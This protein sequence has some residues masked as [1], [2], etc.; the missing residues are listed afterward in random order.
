MPN[1]NSFGKGI[2]AVG[3][4]LCTLAML[5]LGQPAPSS[6]DDLEW[7]KEHSM[8]LQAPGLAKRFSGQGA[9]W[10]H[11]YALARPEDFVNTASVWFTAYPAAIIGRSGDSV[12]QT[13]G[14]PN[15]LRT[16]AKI[17]FDGIHTGPLKRAGSVAGTQY[18]PTIDGHFDRIELAIDP[19]FGT[20]A[21]YQAMIRNAAAR[22]ISIIGDLIPGHTGKGPDFRLAER[23]VAGFPGLYLMVEI[24]PEDWSLL[25]LV[26]KGEDSVNLSLEAVQALKDR[27]YIVGPLD[28]VIFARPGIKESNWS[29]TDVVTGAD[30]KDRRW[31]YLHFFKRGQPALNW[32]DPSFAAHRLEAADIIHS[33][34]VLGTRALRLD[35]NMFLGIGPRKGNRKAWLDGHPL[36]NGVT[37]T[38][39]M[40]IRKLGG[41]SFQELNVPLEKVHE[42][43][44]F[45]PELSY[46][47]T[48]RPAY[49]YA[50]V[51]GNAGPLRMILREMLA[52]EVRPM[53]M[54]HALQNHDE[55]MMELTH[56]RVHGEKTFAF[57]GEAQ[58][59]RAL[60]ARLHREPARLAT[61]DPAPYNER[62]ATSPGICST[63]AGLVAPVFGVKDRAAISPE[64]AAEIRNAHLAAAAY[65][66]LQPGTFALS[67]W[68]VVGALPVSRGSVRDR[69]AD[70]DCRWL[71]RG[72][73]DLMGVNQ[74]ASQSPAGLP[75]AIALYGPLP[76]QLKDPASFAARL[77]E[78]LGVRKELGIA[79]GR[80][81]SVPQVSKPGA[82]L[83]VNELPRRKGQSSR[84][85]VTAVNFGRSPVEEAIRD[86]RIEADSARAIFSTH[87]G[88]I[89]EKLTTNGSHAVV[90]LEPLE[91][92]IITQW[93]P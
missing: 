10:R 19:D 31:V 54:V 65:N 2:P 30:G 88:P 55:L 83:L 23:N 81:V 18:R 22:G 92:K 37:E 63:I 14:D 46:D 58:K 80:L 67:G 72:A 77:K 33:L 53:R 20:K 75:R 78:M 5:L 17:G 13:L 41:F 79:L 64:Q 9:Q 50:L 7:F 89:D 68:D 12:L 44:A 86:Q 6:A 52:Y 43:L 29:A 57:E 24:R 91:A 59:G 25:P 28:A 85:Q 71:N 38:I 36:S 40:M 21:Q 45:G 73:Y 26:P 69:L 42:S 15:L 66:A 34:H 8:L 93:R 47:F 87:Q 51:T 4:F 11:P 82:L 35:A 70:N 90:Q 48:T 1:T 27:G 56:L 60:F 74:G 84:V 32:L 16:L 62:F 49:F 39:A 3:A 76:D 61:G